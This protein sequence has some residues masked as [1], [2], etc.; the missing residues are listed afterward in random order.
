MDS[1][2]LIPNSGSMP[3]LIIFDMD[4]TVVGTHDLI[5]VSFEHAVAE[6]SSLKP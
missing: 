1:I 2:C 3:S 6:F 5:A 4:D